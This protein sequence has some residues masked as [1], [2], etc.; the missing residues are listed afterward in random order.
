MKFQHIR[1]S[2]GNTM[3][4]YI[5]IQEWNL[6]KEKYDLIEEKRPSVLNPDQKKELDARLDHLLQSPN[7][8][9]EWEDVKSRLLLRKK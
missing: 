5:P 3:G 1:D 4:V 8:L 7:D 9:L 6:F 2:K